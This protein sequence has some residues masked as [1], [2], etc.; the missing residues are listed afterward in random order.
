MHAPATPGDSVP[1][2]AAGDDSGQGSE[3][4][5]PGETPVARRVDS[6]E[7]GTVG[8]TKVLPTLPYNYSVHLTTDQDLMVILHGAGLS[9]LEYIRVDYITTSGAYQAS[10]FRSENS[11]DTDAYF[12]ADYGNSPEQLYI[13][14]IASDDEY[15]YDKRGV[16]KYAKF[17]I[18]SNDETMGTVTPSG[19]SRYDAMEFIEATA[20]EGYHFVQWSDGDTRRGRNIKLTCD[21]ELTAIF[22]PDGD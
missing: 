18:K 19:T 17:T 15:F 13:N 7:F 21:I 5:Q 22:A 4:E 2:D 10:L 14:Y 11:T 6:V 3:P 12:T 16:Q 9:D 1:G 20:E 8:A